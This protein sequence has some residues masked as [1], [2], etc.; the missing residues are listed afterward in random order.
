MKDLIEAMKQSKL[1][2]KE[3]Q[4]NDNDVGSAGYIIGNKRP[5]LINYQ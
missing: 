3:I 4:F 5:N 2:F 1:P